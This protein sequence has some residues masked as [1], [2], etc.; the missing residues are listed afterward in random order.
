MRLF[1]LALAATS[2][3]CADPPPPAPAR[4][5]STVRMTAADPA[6]SATAAVDP[7]AHDPPLAAHAAP[8]AAAKAHAAAS[9]TAALTPAPSADASPAGATLFAA[10]H[11]AC[12]GAAIFGEPYDVASKRRLARF[13][14]KAE[15]YVTRAMWLGARVLVRAC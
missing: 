13:P 6:A 9:L 15:S 3:A 1:V 5:T 2:L 14:L 7:L 11:E 4:P 8:P 10:R 12:E